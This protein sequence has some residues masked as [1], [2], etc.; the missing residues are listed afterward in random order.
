MDLFEWS[1]Q[2]LVRNSKLKGWS[3][4]GEGPR[5]DVTAKSSQ[6]YLV[7]EDLSSANDADVIITPNSKANITWAAA[8]FDELGDVRI[9]FTNPNADAY[10]TLN[11]RMLRTFGDAARFKKT[12]KM[13]TGEVPLI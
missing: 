6:R 5:Y 13:F 10:W 7:V 3:V 4:S 1:H 12:P 11:V 9:I 2:F 8:H